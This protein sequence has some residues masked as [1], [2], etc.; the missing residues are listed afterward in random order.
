[1]PLWQVNCMAISYLV[2]AAGGGTRTKV[3]D[4]LIPKALLQLNGV[5][6]LEHAIR[7]LS[8]RIEDQVIVRLK[9]RA[10]EDAK[11]Q[12]EMANLNGRVYF[13]RQNFILI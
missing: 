6:L 4:Q 7:S 9:H 1:M 5:C 3:I 13:S 11:S 10:N 8:I 12:F 2:C